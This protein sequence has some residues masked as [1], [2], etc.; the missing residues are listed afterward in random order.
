MDARFSG[1]TAIVTGSSS[2]IG[3]ATALRLAR[4]GAKVCVVANNNV[5]GGQATAQEIQDS[6]GHALFVQA[7][8]GIGDDCRRI[9]EETLQAFGRVDVLVN[10]AGITRAAP[11]VEME[12]DF[13]DRVVGTNLKS[14]YLMSRAVI[15]SMLENGGGS[16]VNISSVHAE[17]T[18]PG[19]SAYAASKAGICGLTRGLAV[20]FG[21]RGIRFNCILPGTID[22][23]I[24]SRKNVEVDRETWQP[25]T[26]EMQVLKRLG[27]PDEV[28]AAIC[29]LASEEASFVNGATLTVDGG[30]LD[31]LG[32]RPVVPPQ[33]RTPQGPQAPQGPLTPPQARS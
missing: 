20:E 6:G 13:W 1:K 31:R 28:A 2:G 27:S 26:S 12:E 21:A 14:M 10:N 17:A 9:A 32:D 22:V 24:Y 11:L 3:K 16:V 8:V 7:D 18:V 30:L 4:E 29:F 23:S 15:G 19:C 25:R 33:P 5:E